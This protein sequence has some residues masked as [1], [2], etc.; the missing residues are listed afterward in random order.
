MTYKVTKTFLNSINELLKAATPS[1]DRVSVRD[2][3][4]I[5]PDDSIIMVEES[6][7]KTEKFTV[8]DA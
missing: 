4:E 7:V 1:M 6:Y 2:F 8:N 5:H 3:S